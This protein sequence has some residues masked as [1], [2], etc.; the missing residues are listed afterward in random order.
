MDRAL[1]LKARAIFERALEIEPENPLILYHLAYTEYCLLLYGMAKKDDRLFNKFIDLAIEHTRKAMEIEG[2]WSELPALLSNLYGIKIANNWLYGPVLGPK[3]SDLIELAIK[4][5][6]ANP[7]AWLIRGIS[8]F[9]TPAIFGGDL[10]EAIESL[11]RA[12][13]LF[14]SENKSETQPDWGYP[15]AFIWLGICYEK[16]K[17]LNMAIRCYEKA[18]E[19]EPDFQ[20]AKHKIMK[21]KQKYGK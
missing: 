7:R 14:E 19:I 9:N 18:L 12:I 11:K 16:R 4:L 17:E 6:S 3:S 21:L 2:N 5:D 1:L 15:D 8:K 20:W 10:N 13:K